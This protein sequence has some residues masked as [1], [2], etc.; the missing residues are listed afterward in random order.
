MDNSRQQYTEQMDQINKAVRT[1]SNCTE[2]IEYM[3]IVPYRVVRTRLYTVE[4]L[5]D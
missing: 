5:Y 1:R 4:E 2:L 3:H